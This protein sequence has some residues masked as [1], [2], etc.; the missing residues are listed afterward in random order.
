MIAG[1][2]GVARSN[3]S[4]VLAGRRG[5]WDTVVKWMEA[6]ADH[7]WPPMVAMTDGSWVLVGLTDQFQ[8]LLDDGSERL[9]EGFAE[10]VRP[11]EVDRHAV[12]KALGPEAYQHPMTL[13][14]QD[15]APLHWHRCAR[16][17]ALITGTK[18]SDAWL[19]AD[20]R[21]L[22]LEFARS[23]PFDE[24]TRDLLEEVLRAQLKPLDAEP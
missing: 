13:R 12:L 16:E 10:V 23:N 21:T 20:E 19:S 2:L 1:I 9:F 6:W 14:F 3:Y 18:L 8:R 5:S 15:P 17:L 24:K 7:G 11:L 22:H 4:A